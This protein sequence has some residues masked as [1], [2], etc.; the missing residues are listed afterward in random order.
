MEHPGMKPKGLRPISRP[1]DSPGSTKIGI[2]RILLLDKSRF[3]PE[4]VDEALPGMEF[5]CS[6]GG[7]NT[8]TR[9][10]APF[11][12][13]GNGIQGF[14]KAPSEN[15]L[16]KAEPV[17]GPALIAI[18]GP[19]SFPIIEPEPVLSSAGGTGA[20]PPDQESG[21][22]SKANQNFRPMAFADPSDEIASPAQCVVFDRN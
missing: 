6:R 7:S 11:P 3:V 5:F 15:I 9:D 21:I 2:H 1:V 12:K 22:D 14:R 16:K 10:W 18:E 17:S 8:G 13:V 4:T 20:V 19:S